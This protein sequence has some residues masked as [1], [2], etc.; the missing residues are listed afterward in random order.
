M[1]VTSDTPPPFRY[2]RPVFFALSGAA[3]VTIVALGQSV[4]LPFLLAMVVAYVLFPLVVRVERFMPRW[5]AILLVYTL[6]IGAMTGF[7]WAIIPR[8]FVETKTLS[9]EL[10]KLTA[11]VRDNYLPWVDRRLK[12]WSGVKA[13]DIKKA[14]DRARQ[15]DPDVPQPPSSSPGVSPIVITPHKDGSYRVDIRKDVRIEAGP[16]GSW[17]LSSGGPTPTKQPFSSARALQDGLDRAVAY[18]QHN[19][20][21]LLRLGRSIVASVSRGIFYFFLTLMLA[22]YMMFTYE[23]ILGFAREMSPSHRRPRFD[24]FLRHLD[25]GLSGVVRGQ[26]IICLVNGIL[27]AIGFWLLGLKYWPILSLIA[28][29]MSIIPIFGSILSSIPAV[30]I[31]LT[32]SF[33]TAAWV[34]LWIVGIHQLEANFLNPKIIGD[35]AKIHPVLVVFALLF[36]EHFFQITGALLAVPCLSLV[37]TLFLHFR[38][39]VLGIPFSPD[40]ATSPGAAVLAADGPRDITTDLAETA[41]SA[42]DSADD[43]AAES[44]GSRTDTNENAPAD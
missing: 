12:K 14:E 8:L 21:E 6:T 23:G 16:G 38:E 39:S 44:N 13:T 11:R 17:V 41:H 37:Q 35:Q 32:Q 1:L 25:R 10:P 20:F 42:A 26:L 2:A 7:G 40:A 24:H 22:G 43:A 27:S 36:G 30:A 5:V 15:V 34:L 18:A 33:G 4:L 19:S 3:L 29:I 31:G 28:G 9:A